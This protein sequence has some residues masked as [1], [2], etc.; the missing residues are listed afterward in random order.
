[1]ARSHLTHEGWREV[2]QRL[3]AESDISAG[4]VA[5]QAVRAMRR[6]QL[7]V[8]LPRPARFRWYLKRI[9]PQFFLRGISKAVQSLSPDHQNGK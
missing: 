7:Y 4:D 1:V 6:K 3:T 2:L 5:D 9:A 8:M